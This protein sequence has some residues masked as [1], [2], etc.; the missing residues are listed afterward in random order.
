MVVSVE[1]LPKTS[2][3]FEVTGW[4]SPVLQAMSPSAIV[5]PLSSYEYLQTKL[6]IQTYSG[7]QVATFSEFLS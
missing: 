1:G 5:K 4:L 6:L 7:Q 2:C 3:E